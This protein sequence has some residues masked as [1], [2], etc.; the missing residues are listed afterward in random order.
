[1]FG[2]YR[3]TDAVYKIHDFKPNLSIQWRWKKGQ[4]AAYN[5]IFQ[6][7]SRPTKHSHIKQYALAKLMLFLLTP[8]NCICYTH[9]VWF[10]PNNCKSLIAEYL[11]KQKS[12]ETVY[13][14]SHKITYANCRSNRL[15]RCARFYPKFALIARNMFQTPMK[16]KQC[17]FY[18]VFFLSK[19]WRGS[20]KNACGSI[21][22]KSQ[23]FMWKYWS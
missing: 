16:E 14:N 2:I 19:Q 10:Q 15:K 1:M 8:T 7:W 11:D 6:K 20:K 3:L 4:Q 13:L 21:P 5:L 9:G 23:D 18:C 17:S 22:L 12:N